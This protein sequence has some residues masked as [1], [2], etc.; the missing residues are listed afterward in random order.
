MEDIIQKKFDE[1]SRPITGSV[2]DRELS[3]HGKAF[4]AGWL[5]A[6][7]SVSGLVNQLHDA[8]VLKSD[9]K[10]LKRETQMS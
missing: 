4:T 2:S 9:P 1:W 6:L 8:E 5:A 7:K 10:G 3:S